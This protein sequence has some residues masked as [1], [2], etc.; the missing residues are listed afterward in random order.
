VVFVALI[1]GTLVASICGLRLRMLSTWAAIPAFSLATVFVLGETTMV[2]RVPFALRSFA[3]LLLLLLVLAGVAAVRRSRRSAGPWSRDCEPREDP[4]SVPIEKRLSERVD[5]GLLAL[6]VALGALTW[7]RGLRGVP[8]IPPGGDATRHGWFVERIISGQTIDPTRVV[9]SDVGGRHPI[10]NFYPLAL[11]ASAAIST[12]IAGSDV[13]GVLVAYIVVFSTVVLPVGMFV[14]ARTL[15]PDRPLVAGFTA[16]VAPLLTV[17]PYFP[18]RVGD[19]PQ[20][21][22]M[23][24]VPVTVVLLQQ[25]TLARHQ[26]V[27]LD[28]TSLIALV[29]AALAVLCIISLHTSE[30]PLI[31]LLPLLLVLERAWREHDLPMLRAAL[32]RGVAAGAFATALF[33][34][35]L[36]SFVGGVAERVPVRQL[37]ARPVSWESELGTILQL[38]LG[39][40]APQGFLAILALTGAALWLSWR[41]PAWVAGWVGV[42]LLALLANASPNRFADPFTFPWYHLDARIVP[43]VAFFVPFFASVALASAAALITRLSG[44]S[45][46]ILPA[47]V[48][49]IALLAFF[50]GLHGF[51]A[52]SAYV[53]TSFDPNS[54]SFI[55]EAGVAPESLAAFQWLHV[56]AAPGDTVANEPNAGGSLWM[57]AEEHVAPL[58]GPYDTVTSADLADRAYLTDHLQSL[59]HNARADDVARR[60]HTRWIFFDRHGFVLARRVM[61]LPGLQHNPHLTAVFHEGGTWVFRIDL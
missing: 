4:T 17:F 57:Y 29:P 18:V 51:R 10:A 6:G 61:S 22:A 40:T 39:G 1:P 16:L 60:Y 8:L 12:R 45:W 20:I 54:G 30:L 47:T 46:V 52:D 11:H 7:R 21:V 9:T 50:V 32:V 53:H 24:L 27:L 23:A 28:R 42:V 48:A 58:L 31:V 15:A 2:L 35:T 55:S 13:G 36:V 43:N 26:R 33:A 14:L 34:P 25:A 49:M 59:G 38:H 19:I 5:Y 56:H 41:R 37:L 44:R 3:V